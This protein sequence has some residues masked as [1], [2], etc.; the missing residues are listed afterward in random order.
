MEAGQAPAGKENWFVMVNAP[1]G[2]RTDDPA[3]VDTLREHVL[4]KLERML[5]TSIRSHL[6][7]ERVL[8]PKGIEADTATHLG[9]LYGT[10]SNTPMAAFLR[11]PNFSRRIQGLYFAGG[12]VHPG[13]GI[14]LCLKSAAIVAALVPDAG[15]RTH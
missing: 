15:Q 13:G 8:T 2:M 7:V 14:P 12:S 3:V 5:G 9:A 6:E 10:S 1:A 4:Q 11:H